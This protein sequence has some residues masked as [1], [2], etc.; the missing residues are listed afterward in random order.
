MTVLEKIIK[1]YQDAAQALAFD[2]SFDMQFGTELTPQTLESLAAYRAAK[3]ALRA[4]CA[5][6]CPGRNIGVTHDA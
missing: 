3:K 5:A 4:E 2:V 1:E 6:G